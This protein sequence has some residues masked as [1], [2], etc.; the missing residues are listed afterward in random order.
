MNARRTEF[1]NRQQKKRIADLVKEC[2]NK[3]VYIYGPYP[4]AA[5]R[6]KWRIVIYDPSTLGYSSHS[7]S[8]ASR[9]APSL[10]RVWVVEIL[11]AA[12]GSLGSA[13]AAR[14]ASSV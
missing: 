7:A 10:G 12:A 14:R 3:I 9:V 11:G 4:P 8:Q 5:G 2:E 6:T 1:E 13:S